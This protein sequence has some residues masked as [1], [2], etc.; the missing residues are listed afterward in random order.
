MKLL[1]ILSNA[2]KWQ[3]QLKQLE[4]FSNG[5]GKTNARVITPTNHYRSKHR[6]EPIR[7]LS[8]YLFT[9]ESA[10]K[11]ALTSCDWFWFCFSLV[12]KVGARILSQSLSVASQL[13]IDFGQSFKNPSNG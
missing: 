1:E 12:G 7:I 2:L 11:I 13:R 3:I 6:D 4:W 9:A 10:E 5:C 8:N